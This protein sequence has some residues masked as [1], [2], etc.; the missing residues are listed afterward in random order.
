MTTTYVATCE[1]DLVH[2]AY[3]PI[4]EVR[5]DNATYAFRIV[6]EAFFKESNALRSADV[7]IKTLKG[8]GILPWS[9]PNQ[10]EQ[11]QR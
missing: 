3:N 7:H 1:R 10:Y 6:G 8:S 5:G 11:V 2:A 4:I 9:L